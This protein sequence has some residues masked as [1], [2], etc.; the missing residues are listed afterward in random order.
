MTMMRVV[1][2]ILFPP[3]GILGQ[4]LG[5][6]P[7]NARRF[8]QPSTSDSIASRNHPPRGSCRRTSRCSGPA[9]LA[10]ARAD[11]LERL[12][13]GSPEIVTESDVGGADRAAREIADSG[14]L[15]EEFPEWMTL[16]ASA[17]SVK[18]Y[19]SALQDLIRRMAIR[20]LRAVTAELIGCHPTRKTS[21]NREGC[22]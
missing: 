7:H 13:P 22:R 12:L 11:W 19:R 14:R 10:F 6:E 18:T 8:A 17:A 1:V 15:L 2:D 5:G 21:R 9:A 3:S 4:V 16:Y 20:D